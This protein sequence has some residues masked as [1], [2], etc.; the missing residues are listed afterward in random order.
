MSGNAC[1]CGSA[2]KPCRSLIHSL[3][4]HE[5]LRSRN[6]LKR[7][8]LSMIYHRG[9]TVNSM[10]Y[11][12]RIVCGFLI[13]FCLSFPYMPS[14]RSCSY[15]NFM[16]SESIIVSIIALTKYVLFFELKITRAQSQTYST[17]T[18]TQIP[19]TFSPS[20][21]FNKSSVY[22]SLISLRGSGLPQE[23]GAES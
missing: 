14:E 18:S 21:L 1:G 3:F 7:S 8:C 13:S 23:E 6:P 15:F 2:E 12:L 20:S 11:S 5:E 16:D 10:S 4:T 22:Q 19:P 9:Q 17:K